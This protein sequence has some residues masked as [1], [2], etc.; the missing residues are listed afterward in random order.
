MKF[1][2]N[3]LYT[4]TYNQKRYHL[5][6]TK[7]STTSHFICRECDLH[8]NGCAAVLGNIAKINKYTVCSKLLNGNVI[9]PKETKL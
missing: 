8:R 9:V 2:L 7:S 3:K 4:T 5:R 6:M 1:K